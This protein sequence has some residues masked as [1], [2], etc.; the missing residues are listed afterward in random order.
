MA[1]GDQRMNM[2]SSK[3]IT[4]LGIDPALRNF[5]FAIAK[6]DVEK[7]EIVEI[8]DLKLVRTEDQKGKTVRRNSDDLRR[9]T[10][11]VNALKTLSKKVAISFAEVPVGSQSARAMASYGICIGILASCESGLIQVT[12]TQVKVEAV[13]DKTATKEEMIEWASNKFPDA[14]WLKTKFRGQEK[15]KN[16]NEH[17]ADAI[18]AINAG[19]KSTDWL[20]LRGVI[21]E[22][23]RLNLS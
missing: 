9:A 11:H 7:N 15:L 8:L 5:G 17:L 19:L 18:G 13:G 21:L 20:Q 2:N 1:F 6:V 14:P 4:V 23:S 16:E 3:T 12:P 10:Q 22:P